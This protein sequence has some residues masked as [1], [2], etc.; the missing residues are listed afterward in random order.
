MRVH[1]CFYLLLLIFMYNWV[2]S[3]ANF[4]DDN[5]KHLFSYNVDLSS[6]NNIS[7]KT[8]INT[9]KKV[10]LA[11]KI[12]KGVGSIIMIMISSLIVFDNITLS[13]QLECSRKREEDLTARLNSAKQDAATSRLE[14]EKKVEEMQ[15]IINKIIIHTINNKNNS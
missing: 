13:K 11:K 8:D 1:I 5:S 6:F 4:V 10:A 7:K 12:L 15:N 2:F 14:Y 9:K 3:T